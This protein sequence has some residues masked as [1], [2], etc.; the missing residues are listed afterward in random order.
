MEFKN[1]ELIED[2]LIAKEGFID[3]I[4]PIV[5]SKKDFTLEFEIDEGG[6]TPLIVNWKWHSRGLQA[7]KKLKL[8][9]EAVKSYLFDLT[10]ML[11]NL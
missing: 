4:L 8:Q 2:L 11:I 6:D 7:S 1:S 10:I 3:D 5:S 9:L